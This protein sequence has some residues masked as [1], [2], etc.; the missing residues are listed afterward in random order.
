M[1]R[2]GLGL[3]TENLASLNTILIASVRDTESPTS[4][5]LA[6]LPRGHGSHLIV[7]KIDFSVATDAKAAA[8]A[9]QSSHQISK[10]DTVI[11]NAAVQNLIFD[12]LET[13][14]PAQLQEHISG[15]AIGT[16]VLYQAM[17]PLLRKSSQPKFVLLGSP[18]GSIGGMEKR[19]WPMN[20]Y[21]VSKAAA[22]YLVRKIHFE[23][24]QLTAFSVDPG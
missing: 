19:P 12:P 21:G 23:N 1:L 18:M 24:E 2:I 3:A 11:A 14:N 16:L 5:A 4:K 17:L 20:A 7:V 6:N 13:V 22:H 15:N 8:S 9:L 10:L